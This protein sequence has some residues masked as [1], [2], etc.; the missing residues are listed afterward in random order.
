MC[1]DIHLHSAFVAGNNAITLCFR[2]LAE[3]KLYSIRRRLMLIISLLLQF[4]VE[5]SRA[6][7]LLLISLWH[8]VK[9]IIII[10][11]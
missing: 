4:E 1:L 11:V 9:I 10:R 5:V 7:N 3:W 6:L 2:S 8:L